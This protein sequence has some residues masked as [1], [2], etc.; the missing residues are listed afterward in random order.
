MVRRRAAFF[1]A[2]AEAHSSHPIAESIK[3]AY[4]SPL[5][6]S[7]I[8]AYEDIAGHGIKATISGSHV[9][10]GNYR[11]MEREG[12]AYEKEKEAEPLC[13]WQL[14]VSLPDQS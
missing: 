1:A 10:A 4:S 9:L 12:I 6:E 3:A 8:E 2:L 7:Q 13:T 5:D 14:T 11:L